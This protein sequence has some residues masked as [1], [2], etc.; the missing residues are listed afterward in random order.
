MNQKIFCFAL[1]AL[2]FALSVP[3]EAQQADK[4]YRIGYLSARF[5]I[6]RR[7]EGFRQGLRELGYIEGRNIAVEWRFAKRKIDR[8]PE[9]AAELVRLKL[10]VIVTLGTTPTRAARK[11]TSTIPIVMANV[12]DPVRTGIV[13]SLARPEGNITG[14]TTLSPDLA[15][16]RLELLKEAF[17]QI[18]RVAALWDSSRRM[19]E[20]QFKETET[21]ARE[22]GVQLQSL[23][24][25]RL[26]YNLENVFRT[27]VKERIEALSQ[28]GCCFWGHRAQIVKLAVKNRLPVMYSSSRMVR[29]GG[30]MAYAPDR[31]DQLRRAAIYVDKILKGAKP[32]DLPIEQPTKFEL[33]I[34]LKAAKQ[35]GV[36]IPPSILYRADKVIK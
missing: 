34:N 15:G 19:S 30:L 6:D 12:G 35:I 7:E 26:P 27:A 25:K 21:A 29:A 36:T 2:V 16:K 23:T 17:P 32:G 1:C 10:D 5:G 28:L 33:V 9:L 31:V 3:V 24:V 13:A 8:L 22:L 20:F 4:V 14:L 11:A 18:S